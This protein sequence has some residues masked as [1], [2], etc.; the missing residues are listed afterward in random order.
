MLAVFALIIIPISLLRIE[1]VGND[2]LTTR[3]ALGASNIADQSK[4]DQF[5]SIRY[6]LNGFATLARFLG[7]AMIPYLVFFVPIGVFLVI[8]NRTLIENKLLIIVPIFMLMPALYAYSIPALD[9]R[10]L[11][12]L[13]PIF[14]IMSIYTIRTLVKNITI[15]KT[16]V[17]LFVLGMILLSSFFLYFKDVDV[18]HEKE[19]LELAYQVVKKTSV[20]YYYPNESSYL[21]VAG[22]SNTE[23]FPTSSGNFSKIPKQLIVDPQINTLDDAINSGRENGL[24]HLV[25]D[26]SKNRPTF[27]NDAFYY[28]EKYPYLEKIFDSKDY[29]YNYHL[30]I[31]KINYEKFD[32]FHKTN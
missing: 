22:I 1:T 6:I 10:Y 19:A 18:L 15:R 17:I 13:Y 30:K 20:I 7:Q 29:G 28:E 3:V 8:K 5:G 12:P 25:L 9:S 26:G 21:A 4:G 31:F 11:L 24:T 16:L 32:S 23:K 27:F 2:W 14:S